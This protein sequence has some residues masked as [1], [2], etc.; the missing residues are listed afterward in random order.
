MTPSTNRITSRFAGCLALIVITGL[1][2]SSRVYALDDI[3][4]LAEGDN[5]YVQAGAYIHFSS[6]EDHEGP[7]IVAAAELA[8]ST[9]WIYGLTLFNNSFGQFSQY[10]YLGKKFK[11][12][13]IHEAL[14]AKLTVGALHGYRGE[15]QDKIP[16]N[17]LG[18][19]PAIIPSIG[20][21]KGR[22]GA[23]IVFLASEA[24]LFTIGFDIL[25]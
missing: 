23:D 24:I 6:S 5:I 25:P 10:L 9:D 21:K 16:F 14:H 2:V 4:A 1:L 20:M 22:Y 19:A 8:R 15:F 18:V 11:F 3:F 13:K 7:P 12:P 17:D